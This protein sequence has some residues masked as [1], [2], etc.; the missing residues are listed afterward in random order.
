MKKKKNK[1]AVALGKLRWSKTTY[2]ER[3]AMAHRLVAARV[4]KRLDERTSKLY[5]KLVAPTSKVAE[6]AGDYD[7]R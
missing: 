2:K 1:A 5:D 6:D 3:V 4:K 7:A